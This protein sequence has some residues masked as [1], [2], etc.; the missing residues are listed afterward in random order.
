MLARPVKYDDGIE[1]TELVSCDQTLVFGAHVSL[2]SYQTTSGRCES[3]S[4]ESVERDHGDVHF[5]GCSW[6]SH[7]K[8]NIASANSSKATR[9]RDPYTPTRPRS[10]C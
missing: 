5:E 2:V 10:S 7:W 4:I 9:L 1:A 8:G 3:A 6:V